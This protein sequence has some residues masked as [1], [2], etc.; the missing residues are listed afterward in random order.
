MPYRFLDNE[1]TADIAFEAFAKDLNLV[2]RDASEALVKVMIDNPDIIE[3]RESRS[4]RLDNDQLDLLLYNYL[5]QFI[6]YKDRDSLLLRPV[7]VEL[8]AINDK[9]QLNATAS[10]EIID[11]LRHHLIVDVK[12]VTLHDF[13]LE[14]MGSQWRAHVILD[15]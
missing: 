6:F 5:E 7:K 11:P 4:F 8:R 9:W 14:N 12:A 10:G 2:F 1:T 13:R 15:I 3:P